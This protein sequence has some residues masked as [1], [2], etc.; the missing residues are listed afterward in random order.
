VPAPRNPTVSIVISVFRRKQFLRNAISSALGQT[1]GDIEVIVAEDGGSDCAADIVSSFSDP[2]L[3]LCRCDR[4]LGEA[5]NRVRAYRRARGRYLVNLDDDDALCPEF[6]E[7]LLPPLEQDAG[8]ILAFSDHYVMDVNGRIDPAATEA[9]TRAFGRDKLCEGNYDPLRELGLT[10]GTIPLNV[11]TLFRAELIWP[12]GRGGRP[13]LPDEAGAADD[14]YLTY[15]ACMS[16]RTA[17]YLPKRLSEYRVHDGQ[18]TALRLPATSEGL[19]FCHRTFLRDRQLRPWRREL[20][21]RLAQTTTTLGFDLLGAGNASRARR[22]FAESLIQRPRLRAAAGLVLTLL[23]G[24]L[25]PR[26]VEAYRRGTHPAQIEEV[27]Q[28]VLVG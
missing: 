19:L 11:A 2:R 9:C 22:C 26:A 17:Y 8:L 25:A 4:N 18:L 28:P 15:L 1:F 7:S 6:V 13:A 23:P 24:S 3:R 16:G 5:G 21:A 10:T 20:E 12:A 14:L 27:A